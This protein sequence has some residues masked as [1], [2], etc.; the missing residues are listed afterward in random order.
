M[1]DHGN[2]IQDMKYSAGNVSNLLWYVE[3]RETARLLQKRTME[4]TLHLVMEE[5]LYQ[6]RSRTRLLREF[7]CIRKRLEA[8]PESL[9]KSLPEM[10]INTSKLV[11]LIGAMATDRLLFEL[12]YEVYGDHLRLGIEALRNTDILLFFQRKAEQSAV[13]AGWSQSAIQKLKQTYVKY[14]LEAGL[15]SNVDKYT[16]RIHRIYVSPEVKNILSDEDME[17]FLYALTGER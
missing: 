11:V 4:E 10:D 7:Q 16:K 9:V 15:I 12:L 6:Q 5:N 1:P 8:L 17:V 3:T 14:M 2:P 13:V